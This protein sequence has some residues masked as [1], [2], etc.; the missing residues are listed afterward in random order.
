MMQF[1]EKEVN[2]ILRACE[3]YKSAIGNQDPSIAEE[4]DKVNHK[5]HSYEQEMDC[6]DCW[7][8]TSTCALH[9]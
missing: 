9:V 3:Y 2:R 8:P 4:Y 5:L 7:D 6:P 1:H